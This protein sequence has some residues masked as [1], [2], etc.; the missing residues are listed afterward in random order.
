[1]VRYFKPIGAVEE[2][3]AEDRCRQ[4]L[5]EVDSG[6]VDTPN[7]LCMINRLLTIIGGMSTAVA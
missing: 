2:T 7:R 4:V 1:M 6:Y 3:G 5:G